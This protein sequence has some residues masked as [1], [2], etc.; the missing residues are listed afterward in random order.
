MTVLS[1]R[2]C[3]CPHKLIEKV[4]P[5]ASDPHV[6]KFAGEVMLRKALKYVGTAWQEMSPSD[7]GHTHQGRRFAYSGVL[8]T[9]EPVSSPIVHSNSQPSPLSS[10]RMNS[11]ASLRDGLTQTV[12]TVVGAG[13]GQRDTR[14]LGVGFPVGHPGAQKVGSRPVVCVYRLSIS[15]VPPLARRLS[16]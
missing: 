4:V 3:A 14:H 16:R 2:D 15:G 9:A 8:V 11:L 7:V 10:H 1:K 12:G 13:R 5:Q 6:D